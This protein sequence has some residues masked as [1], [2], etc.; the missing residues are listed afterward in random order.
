MNNIPHIVDTG[1]SVEDEKPVAW[2]VKSKDGTWLYYDEPLVGTEPLYTRAASE[3]KYSD[4]WWQGVN[5][6]AEAGGMIGVLREYI[7]DLENG[8]E[9]SIKLNKA[10]AERNK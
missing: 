3:R 10:Q 1:A 2:R 5:E 4:E 6:L 8:L 7:S 9:S